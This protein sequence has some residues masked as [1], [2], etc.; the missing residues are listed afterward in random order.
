[1]KSC[2][3]LEVLASSLITWTAQ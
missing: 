3:E 2:F 1:M